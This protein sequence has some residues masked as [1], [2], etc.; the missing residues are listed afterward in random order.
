MRF[1]ASSEP[2]SLT[3]PSPPLDLPRKKTYPPAHTAQNFLNSRSL[4]PHFPRLHAPTTEKKREVDTLYLLPS[5]FLLTK[6][7]QLPVQLPAPGRL[8]EL[9]SPPIFLRTDRIV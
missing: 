5:S 1:R 9:F 4:A 6:G 8:P 3:Y 7:V 2:A